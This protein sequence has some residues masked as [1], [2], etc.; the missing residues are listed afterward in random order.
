MKRRQLLK[1]GV[2][3]LLGVAA[4]SML[5]IELLAQPPSVDRN[6]A[7]LRLCYNE[8]PYGPSPMARNAI[9]EQL[10]FGNQYPRPLG[11]KLKEA[12]A[13]ENGLTS[14]HVLLAAG[15]ASILQLVGLWMGQQQKNIAS[16]DYT[17]SWMMRYASQFGV[18]WIKTPLTDSYHFDLKAIE[19]RITDDIGLVYL[20]QKFYP[21]NPTGTYIQPEEIH[22]FIK[23]HASGTCAVF[24][25]EA[26][27][28]YIDGSEAYNTAHL[29]KQ[30]PHLM[31]CRT[32]SKMYGLAG[33]RVGYLLANPKIID[34]LKTLDIGLGISVSN[35]SLAAALASL[36]DSKFKADS[37]SKN[38]IARDFLHDKLNAWG[39]DFQEG[40]ANFVH[41]DVSPYRDIKRFFDEQSI[42]LNPQKREDK[43]Y[44][45][46]TIGTEE[47]MEL[48]AVE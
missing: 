45:R 30:N 22:P 33:L 46:I 39:V 16:A 10:Q 32:F 11:E 47:E 42:L 9:I 21:N 41:C 28:E 26:Y 17:F 44:L 4:T 36:N 24:V 38:T 23:K 48:F 40:S 29:I 20:C 5:P 18:R 6:A 25:D 8:N 12:I 13:E 43:T 1:S 37:L 35:T 15:S 31:V 2:S 3:G 19:R 34:Q 27:I 7:P 14:D